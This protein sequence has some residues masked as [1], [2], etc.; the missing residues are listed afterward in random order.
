MHILL[1][2]CVNARVKDAF[3]GRGHVVRTVSEISWRG[4][5]DGPL[6]SHAEKSF[7]V[8]VTID[9]KLERQHDLTKLRLGTVV[10]HVP[11]SEISS[12]RPIFPALLSAAA[13]VKPGQVVHVG[14]E[15]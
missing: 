4:T 15:P 5:K 1:D 6:L 13:S 7:G 14:R 8:F 3:Q 10:V 12:Y 11:S 9:R 2:E